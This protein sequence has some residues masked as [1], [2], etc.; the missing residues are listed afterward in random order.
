ML[1]GSMPLPEIHKKQKH[2]SPRVT[3]EHDTTMERA[4][5]G[6]ST[7]EHKELVLEDIHS[8]R[9]SIR[10]AQ[11]ADGLANYYGSQGYRPLENIDSKIRRSLTIPSPKHKVFAK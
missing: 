5:N 10:K 8:P 1:E 2:S 6:Y 7:P 4:I 9:H 3:K 11:V